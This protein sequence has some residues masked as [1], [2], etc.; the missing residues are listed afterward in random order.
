MPNCAVHLSY[1]DALERRE[2]EEFGKLFEDI[3]IVENP[4][5]TFDGLESGQT[6]YVV[7]E[8]EAM[9]KVRDQ[10]RMKQ[11]ASTMEGAIINSAD[12]GFAI[13]RNDGRNLDC[14][15]CIYGKPCTDE[16]G[17]REWSNRFEVA[18]QNGWKGFE[19][20]TYPS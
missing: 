9:Q 15:S 4:R 14:C 8:E 6:L 19:N 18:E 16:Y 11:V 3:Y 13:I 12:D 1:H 17:C 20:T 5:G 10:E 7:V 2:M